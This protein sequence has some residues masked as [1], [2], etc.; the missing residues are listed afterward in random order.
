MPVI[1]HTRTGVCRKY[2]TF[3]H[4]Y[5]WIREQDDKLKYL[6]TGPGD[7]NRIQSRGREVLWGRLKDWSRFRWNEDRVPGWDDFAC[8]DTSRQNQLLWSVVNNIADPVTIAPPWLGNRRRRQ[9][10]VIDL[11][12]CK[13]LLDEGQWL[14]IDLHAPWVPPRMRK[15]PHQLKIIVQELLINDNGFMNDKQL[16]SLMEAFMTVKNMK[17]TQSCWRIFRYYRPILE[18]MKVLR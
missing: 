4:A 14:M 11:D 15:P 7:F 5:L 2:E 17:A 18:Q 3:D 10:T 16:E 6:F 8:A 9:G 13:E 12:R 1:I